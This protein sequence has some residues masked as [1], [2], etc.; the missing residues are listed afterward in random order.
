MSCI[1]MLFCLQPACNAKAT[2]NTKRNLFLKALVVGEKT[3]GS[4][5]NH[6]ENKLTRLRLAL[7][8]EPQNRCDAAERVF[9]HHALFGFARDDFDV[10]VC[11]RG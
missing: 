9:E 8:F 2:Q 5:N 1:C 11:Q 6:K 7:H 10:A 3:G 4:G